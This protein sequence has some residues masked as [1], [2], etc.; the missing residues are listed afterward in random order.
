MLLCPWV[1]NGTRM[2]FST[3]AR[4]PHFWREN[5]KKKTSQVAKS[6]VMAVRDPVFKGICNVAMNH[7]QI[8]TRRNMSR[9]IV[10]EHNEG[11]S[12]V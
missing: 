11:S 4:G 3:R 12:R 6:D 8:H 5:K 2:K 7:S 9:I 10:L 1:A